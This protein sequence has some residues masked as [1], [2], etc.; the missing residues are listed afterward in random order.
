MSDATCGSRMQYCAWSLDCMCAHHTY[1]VSFIQQP[2][3][4]HGCVTTDLELCTISV[5]ISSLYMVCVGNCTWPSM[6]FICVLKLYLY[7]LSHTLFTTHYAF[8]SCG[9]AIT[10]YINAFIFV[11]FLSVPFTFICSWLLCP[12]GPLSVCCGTLTLTSCR[13]REN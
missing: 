11:Q 9:K 1:I 10:V 13:C 12:K 2:T 8:T 6:L 4:L 5:K 7:L 3:A